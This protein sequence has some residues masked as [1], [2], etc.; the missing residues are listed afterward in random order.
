MLTDLREKLSPFY[1]DIGRPSIDSELMLR[2]L[3]GGQ[4]LRH[5]AGFSYDCAR[6]RN[7]SSIDLTLSLLGS[8]ELVQ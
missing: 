3:I 5:P 4:L 8:R 6:P 1:S 7:L 2:M